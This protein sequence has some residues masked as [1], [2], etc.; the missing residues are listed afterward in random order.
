MF[1]LTKVYQVIVVAIFCLA[2]AFAEEP[3]KSNVIN[4]GELELIVPGELNVATE[5]SC[6]PYSMADETGKIDGLEARLFTEIAKR[7]NLKYKPVIV[8]WDSI[9]M[10]LQSGRYDVV[11]TPVDISAERQKRILFA[12]SWLVSGGRLLTLKSSAL[13]NPSDVKG[14]TIGVLV[15][16]TWEDLAK[17]N[18]AGSIKTYKS[19][20]ECV[21]GVINGDVDG[22]IVDGLEAAYAAKLAPVPL[23]VSKESFNEIHKGFALRFDQPN[24]TKAINRIMS[25]L[26]QDGTYA[27]IVVE[28]VDFDPRPKNPIRS[29]FK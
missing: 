10:G 16:S 12:D 4:E 1:S 27:S 5:A 17:N 21:Q 29:L 14:K 7:L 13:S 25:E 11:S 28:F 8:K 2:S 22:M 20:M 3:K 26:M 6:P 23:K 24:L 15:A 18:G 9:L 19:T